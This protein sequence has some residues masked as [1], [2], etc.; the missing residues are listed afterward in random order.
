MCI[1]DRCSAVTEAMHKAVDEM[2]TKENFHGYGPEQGYD[3]LKA[4]VQNYYGQRNVT[5]A[6]D[7]IL[8]VYKR[9]PI[10]RDFKSRD[11]QGTHP[12]VRILFVRRL[13]FWQSP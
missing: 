9:Q 1:R 11:T 5:L 6:L 8:D 10:L 2:A 12:A 7:E 4:A 13:L 3:F